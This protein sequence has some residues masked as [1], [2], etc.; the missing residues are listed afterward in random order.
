M[1]QVER[2]IEKFGGEDQ[3]C[4]ILSVSRDALRKARS[5]H[6]LMPAHWYGPLVYE[7][8]KRGLSIPDIRAFQWER[9]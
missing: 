4:A 7:A 1:N 3:L 5:R 2:E 8:H 6:G 9:G